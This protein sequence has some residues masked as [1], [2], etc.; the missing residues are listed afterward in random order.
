M[1]VLGLV[2]LRLQLRVLTVS[3]QG[4]VILISAMSYKY[5]NNKPARLLLES[6]NRAHVD[7]ERTGIQAKQ[8]AISPARDVGLPLY[9]ANKKDRKLSIGRELIKHIAGR[10]RSVL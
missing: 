5:N 7:F 6:Q 2:S 4:I 9:I 3:R 8:K 10:P 1:I